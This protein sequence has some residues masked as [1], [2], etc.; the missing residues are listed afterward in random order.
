MFL[1]LN[2]W[3]RAA[4][5]CGNASDIAGIGSWNEIESFYYKMKRKFLKQRSKYDI[6]RTKTLHLYH[7]GVLPK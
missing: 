4:G 3:N 6:E 1:Y 7:S 2:G 5:D